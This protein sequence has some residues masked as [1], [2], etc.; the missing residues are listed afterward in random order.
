MGKI[1]QSLAWWAVKGKLSE[2]D[3]IREASRIGYAGFE[4]CPVEQYAPISDA[5]LKIVTTG[6]HES[7]S[8]GLNKEANHDRIER[9][10]EERLALAQKWGIS[11]LIVFSGNRNGLSDTEGADITAKGLGRVA[12]AAE[13]AGVTLIMELLNSKVDH[14]D[15]Q[16]DHTAW[17]VEVCKAVNSSHV[18]LLY[19]IYHMQIMEGDLMRTIA[20]N[21][22][23]IGHF[24]TAGNPGR[25]ELN[26]SQEIYYPPIMQAIAASVYT[27]YVGQEY[28]PTGDPVAAMEQ[29]YRVCDQG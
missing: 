18:K 27:G 24:H 13:S 11:A 7:L 23:Y 10:V 14:A 8:D 19:D 21:L 5:G 4:M 17:G 26:E 29:A 12:K 3:L 20:Q 22:E 28:V 15:Y 16:C 25:H 9:E 1:K 2:A 6:G